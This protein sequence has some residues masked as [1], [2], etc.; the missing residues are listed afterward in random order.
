MDFTLHDAITS[1]FNEDIA[2]WSDGMIKIYNNFA[3]DFLYTNVNNLLIFAENHDTHRINHLYKNDFNKYKMIM[4]LIA[5]VRGIPQLYYGSEIGMAG[6]KDEGDAAIRQ[7]FPGGWKGD[8]NNAFTKAGRTEEQQKYF[9]FISKLF[10]W[11]KG[12]KTIHFGKMTH[13]LPEDN[14]YVYFRYKDNESVMILM[15]NS[16]EEKKVKT[17]RF[18]ES[19]QSHKKGNNILNGSTIDINNDITIEAKSALILELQK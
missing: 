5:T 13:Y 9:D 15:N 1:V 7:D 19:I 14:V 2:S 10:Q 12:N 16:T 8:K 18:Q 17:N 11:R 4:V 6:N 3:N